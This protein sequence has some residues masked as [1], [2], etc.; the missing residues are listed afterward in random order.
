[1]YLV[2]D[3]IDAAAKGDVE[4]VKA[5]LGRGANINEFNTYEYSNPLTTAARNGQ[6]EVVKVLL[7]AG[8]DVNARDRNWCTALMIAAEAG[9]V[10]IV[11][12]LVAANAK[13][14]KKDDDGFTALMKCV[15][16]RHLEVVKL[17]LDA[18]ADINVKNAGWTALDH[19]EK[20][21]TAE[22]VKTLR[23]YS[24]GIKT[25]IMSGDE[26]LTFLGGLKTQAEARD[27]VNEGFRLFQGGDLSGAEVKLKE[28]IALNPNNAVAHVNIGAIY[29]QR[30]LFKDAIP[31]LEKALALDPNVE[32]A[33]DCLK[34]CRK[35][36]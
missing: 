15:R 7:D 8:A 21:S 11:K 18:K 35:F 10:K 34:D 26:A 5:L 31:W 9:D 12:L 6:S 4:S 23:E 16:G 22:I 27:L 1:M 3:L 17:L 13:L 19:A 28:A 30:R 20:Y 29:F 25:S 36:S 24:A 2:D 32:G 14:D 33:G